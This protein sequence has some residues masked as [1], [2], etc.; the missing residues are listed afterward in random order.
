MFYVYLSFIADRQWSLK[1][2]LRIG[3]VE[4]I[5]SFHG[6]K[7]LS[8]SSMLIEPCPSFFIVKASG[9]FRGR[10]RRRAGLVRSNLLTAVPAI[11]GRDVQESAYIWWFY[12]V[13][14]ES[15]LSLGQ[16]FYKNDCRA[17]NVL[18]F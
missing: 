1:L 12:G 6:T 17:Q 18:C 13:P 3:V 15:G 2:N 4:R 7:A 10:V 16:E 14:E 8:R 11:T 5:D 9:M